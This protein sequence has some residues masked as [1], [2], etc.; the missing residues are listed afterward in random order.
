[1]TTFTR[2]CCCFVR[3][4]KAPPCSSQRSTLSAWMEE[5]HTHTHTH[6]S[7]MLDATMQW[8]LNRSVS[9]SVLQEYIIGRCE[10]VTMLNFFT[11]RMYELVP[12]AARERHKVFQYYQII[13]DLISAEPM[14]V[15]WQLAI[16]VNRTRALAIHTRML[17]SESDVI[18]V[19]QSMRLT[20]APE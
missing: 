12:P 1:M 9:M 15:L 18:N 4:I 13:K 3:T 11:R 8:T 10:R 2:T 16:A 6:T 14:V 17:F 20:R 19:R 7:R 5:L